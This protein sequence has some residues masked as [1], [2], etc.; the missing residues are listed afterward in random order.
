[1]QPP[2]NLYVDPDDR[3]YVEHISRFVGLT[4]HVAA[5]VLKPGGAGEI[6][7]HEFELTTDEAGATFLF[8]VFPLLEGFLLGVA[9]HPTVLVTGPGELY[10][11]VGLL[12]GT[13]V[14]Q[15]ATQ[16]LCAGYVVG[17]TAPSWPAGGIESTQSGRGATFTYLTGDPGAGAEVSHTVFDNRR[18]ELRCMQF[19]LLTDATVAN[20]RVLVEVV[21]GGNVLFRTAAAVLQ[22]ASLTFNYNVAP[23]GESG[24]NRNGEILVN[25]PA[26]ILL[27]A[28]DIIR[29]TTPG[30]QA[31]DNYSAAL[32][33]MEDWLAEL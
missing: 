28:G 24:D 20:R 25:Y 23:W 17:P 21:R 11:L 16:I 29:T 30:L 9:V 32:V 12:R 3:L 22:T 26:G 4:F 13:D 14:R 31:G 2:T 7:H 5:R 1:V 33:T 18:A 19:T 15:S 8:E 27:S 6:I 10:V